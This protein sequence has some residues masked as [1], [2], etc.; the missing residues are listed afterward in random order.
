MACNRARMI[1]TTANTRRVAVVDH[2]DRGAGDTSR[3]AV[4]SASHRAANSAA[5]RG[6]NEGAPYPAMA[7]SYA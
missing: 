2:R 6:K 3:T 4:A 5:R 1:A 7:R